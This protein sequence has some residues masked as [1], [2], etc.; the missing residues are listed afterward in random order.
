M[1]ASA[2]AEAVRGRIEIRLEDRLQHQLERHLDQSVFE[3]GNTQWAKLSRLARLRDQSLPDGLR[4]VASLSQFLPDVFQ[5]ACDTIGPLFDC[6]TRHV[7]RARCVAASITSQPFP[8][9]KQRSAIAYDVE[10][11]REPLV[12]VRSTPPIQLALHVENE[13]GIHRVGQVSISCLQVASTARLRHADGFPVLR[14]LC[15]LRLRRACSPVASAI[16]SPR[17]AKA[18]AGSQVPPLPLVRFR[19]RLYPVWIPATEPCRL[20]RL[21]TSGLPDVPDAHP[22]IARRHSTSLS[23]R[24]PTSELVRRLLTGLRPSVRFPSPWR[25]R[26][27]DRCWDRKSPHVRL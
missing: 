2:G 16:R 14:L 27:P 20:S 13:L 6:L 25:T 7:I 23:T 12:W 18:R 17:G 11:I 24:S 15:G 5:K 21:L 26:W 1:G 8:S 10:Q 3:R 4:P 19:S 9:T 22:S